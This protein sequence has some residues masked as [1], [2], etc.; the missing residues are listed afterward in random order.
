MKIRAMTKMTIE[1]SMESFYVFDEAGDAGKKDLSDTEIIAK[2]NTDQ[3]E[4]IFSTR[5]RVPM[6]SATR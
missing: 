1:I 5:K 4:G 3:V 6:T 2:F